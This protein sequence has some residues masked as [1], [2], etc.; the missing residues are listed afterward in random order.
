M[1][2]QKVTLKGRSSPSGGD[3]PSGAAEGPV[4]S[5]AANASV[6]LRLTVSFCRSA[7]MKKEV[8]TVVTDSIVGSIPRNCSRSGL[9]SLILANIA[10]DVSQQ[11]W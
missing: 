9:D 5:I 3:P 11:N 7:E 8:A 10:A 1:A 2:P 4:P 6:A